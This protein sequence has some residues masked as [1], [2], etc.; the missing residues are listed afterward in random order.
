MNC[1]LKRGFFVMRECPVPAT[2]HCGSC[3]RAICLLHT[4]PDLG[5]C[6]ECARQDSD[7]YY[8]DYWVYSYRDQYYQ[9]G[10]E[11]FKYTDEDYASFEAYEDGGIDWDD[12]YAGDFHDS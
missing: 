7:E 9:Q 2:S 11:P 3:Q 8:D 10:Y 4:A 6:V 1:E 12:D 5:T